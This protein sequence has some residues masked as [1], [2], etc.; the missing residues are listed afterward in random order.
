MSSYYHLRII[1]LCSRYVAINVFDMLIFET[2]L[3]NVSPFI[4]ESSVG[5]FKNGYRLLNEV[6]GRFV[7]AV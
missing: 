3:A 6:I 4:D 2:S 7:I 5:L 1:C